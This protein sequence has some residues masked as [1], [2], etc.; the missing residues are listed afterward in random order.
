[1]NTV[2]F[3]FGISRDQP[4]G[5]NIGI[6]F[7]FSLQELLSNFILINSLN[8]SYVEGSIYLFYEG[9]CDASSKIRGTVGPRAE[10]IINSMLFRYFSRVFTE[11][12]W[13]LI[14]CMFCSK[15]FMNTLFFNGF[16]EICINKLFFLYSFCISRGWPNGFNTGIAFVFV[17]Q[18]LDFNFMFFTS[19]NNVHIEGS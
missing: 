18:E 19:L 2:P 10:N 1:M 5:F 8:N 11:A 4:N 17:V 15:N 9:V 3:Y 6:S 14:F 7:F 16:A 13:F 12:W